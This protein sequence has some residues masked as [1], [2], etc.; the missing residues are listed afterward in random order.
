MNMVFEQIDNLSLLDIKSSAAIS[1]QSHK[2]A[3]M[4]HCSHLQRGTGV[5]SVM[6]KQSQDDSLITLAVRLVIFTPLDGLQRYVSSACDLERRSRCEGMSGNA[7][8]LFRVA[9]CG[10][11]NKQT[12]GQIDS[13]RKGAL[14]AYAT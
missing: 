3:A 7:I 2:Q 9:N 5:S 11:Q 13:R 14:K 12:A 6:L 4:G 1:L 10:C 8:D